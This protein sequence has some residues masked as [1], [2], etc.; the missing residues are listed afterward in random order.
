MTQTKPHFRIFLLDYMMTLFDMV[1]WLIGSEICSLTSLSFSALTY[2]FEG[3]D[4]KSF[5][6]IHF[7][8]P[9]FS[10]KQI[11]KFSCTT[12]FTY[13]SGL[14]LN[15]WHLLINHN[16]ISNLCYIIFTKF[17]PDGSSIFLFT[18][19]CRRIVKNSIG[20]LFLF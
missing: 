16:T 5:I 11:T 1:Y 6:C 19:V 13:F 9:L 20:G 7:V 17:Y 12:H 10:V 15:C 14:Y 3:I 4:P 2:S 8:H 18:C